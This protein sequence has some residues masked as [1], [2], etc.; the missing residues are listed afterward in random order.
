MRAGCRNSTF[1]TVIHLRAP[2]SNRHRAES[3]AALQ[4]QGCATAHGVQGVG[5]PR[6]RFILGGDPARPTSGGPSRSTELL[7]LGNLP[8]RASRTGRLHR[9][10]NWPLVAGLYGR[11]A[12]GFRPRRCFAL[13]GPSG[14]V[15]LARWEKRRRSRPGADRG[16]FW[17]DGIYGPVPGWSIFDIAYCILVIIGAD[18]WGRKELLAIADVRIARAPSRGASC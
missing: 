14:K 17:A 7:L 15:E 8:D 11:S 5:R 4:P 9:R 16:Y 2:G 12:G 3:R 6:S 13:E 18:Q 1:A 10:L